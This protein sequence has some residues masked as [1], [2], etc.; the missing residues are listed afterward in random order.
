MFSGI[1]A[2]ETAMPWVDWKWCAE[3]EPFPCSV[4]SGHR[5]EVPNLG[6]VNAEDFVYRQATGKAG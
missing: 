1:L 3:I 2:P 4:I 5:P 6:D